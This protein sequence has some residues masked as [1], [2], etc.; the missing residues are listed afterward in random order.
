KGM[1]NTLQLNWTD[2]TW[3]MIQNAIHDEAM[4]ARVAR[5]FLPLQTPADATTISSDTIRAND[6]RG[7][8][9]LEMRTRTTEIIEL[10]VNVFL[11]Q[12]EAAEPDSHSAI[13]LVT[14]A[15]NLIANA[16]DVVIFQGNEGVQQSPIFPTVQIL[17]GDPGTG[18]LSAPC[19]YAIR[20]GRDGRR[21]FTETFYPRVAEAAAYLQGRH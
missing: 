17:A 18:M 11:T 1:P 15:A 12:A 16:E 5:K 21:T 9:G 4:R 10:A 19:V 6:Q 7:P 2:A 8:Q 13:T 20:V 3:T 14:Y